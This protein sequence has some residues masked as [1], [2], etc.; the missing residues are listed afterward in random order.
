MS[1][2]R[3]YAT[4]HIAPARRLRYWNELVDRIYTGTYVNHAGDEFDG[5]LTEWRLGDLAMIRPRS[6]PSHVGRA[7]THDGAE[8]LILH[9]QCRG[10]SRHVQMGRES[11]LEPGDFVLGTP[12]QPYAI[13]LAAHELLVVEFPRAPLAERFGGLD[14]LMAQRLSA[15]T[16]GGQVFRDFLFSL[17]RQGESGLEDPEWQTGVSAVFYDLVT[18][19][20]RGAT[21]GAVP[22]AQSPLR[23]R[24]LALVEAE[25]G[26]PDLRTPLIAAAC[27]TSVRT[28]QNLF[29]AMG[30]TPG[31]H[32][33]ERRL[34]VAAERLAARPACSVTEVA[35]GVGFNDSA[36]FTRC[37][38]QRFG[39]PP[40]KW[41]TQAPATGVAPLSCLP[42]TPVQADAA[43]AV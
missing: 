31:A 39:R 28:I 42:C 22:L 9:L 41:V 8:R 10:L 11:V 34:Q 12:H 30:T 3:R 19:A 2:I 24:V 43:T 5:E 29:A 15:G 36:Y 17:W 38:R 4:A 1:S 16:P 7:P 35:F 37:F 26:N 27:N 25:L 32:I 18:L 14:D 13:D 20:L 40:R 6:T 23:T 21:R 33:L